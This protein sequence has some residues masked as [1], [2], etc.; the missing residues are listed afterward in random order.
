MTKARKKGLRFG[1]TIRGSSWIKRGTKSGGV[2]SYRNRN[3][4]KIVI[5]KGKITEKILDRLSK[6]GKIKEI[7]GN[8]IYGFDRAIKNPK[9]RIKNVNYQ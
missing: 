8:H 7:T 6:R 2:A 1:D 5:A 4:G 3:T 9:L